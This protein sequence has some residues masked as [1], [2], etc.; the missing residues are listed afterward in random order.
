MHNSE[1]IASSK[2]TKTNKHHTFTTDFDNELITSVLSYFVF[3]QRINL[4][5]AYMTGCI[6]FDI[7]SIVLH[8]V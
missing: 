2:M 8:V 5:V 7:Q 1:I 6:L 4:R 3:V